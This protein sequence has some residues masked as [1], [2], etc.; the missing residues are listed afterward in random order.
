MCKVLFKE[1]VLREALAKM[2]KM[3]IWMCLY[4]F[5]CRY[6]MYLVMIK[7]LTS[8]YKNRMRS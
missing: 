5:C 4:G 8:T 2:F 7:W 6:P 3:N 1:L